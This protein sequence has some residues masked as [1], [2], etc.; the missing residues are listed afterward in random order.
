MSTIRKQH[1]LKGKILIPEDKTV[2]IRSIERLVEHVDANPRPLN[3][4]IQAFKEFIENDMT[5]S[6]LCNTMFHS[7]TSQE[8]QGKFVIVQLLSQI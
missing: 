4:T 7:V 1:T 3:Q 5:V 8:P 2:C 6:L